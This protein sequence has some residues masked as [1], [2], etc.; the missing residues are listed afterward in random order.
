MKLSTRLPLIVL[1]IS[2][3]IFAINAFSLRQQLSQ[4]QHDS[5]ELLANTLIQSMVEAVTHDVILGDQEKLSYLLQRTQDYQNSPIEYLYVTGMNGQIFAHSFNRGIPVFLYDNLDSHRHVNSD[6]R[7]LKLV[8][9]YK[10]DGKGLVYEYEQSL[11][12]GLAARI[13]IG[14]NQS[15]IEAK[16]VTASRDLLLI[17]AFLSL[18]CTLI[19]WLV[20]NGV[21]R[22]FKELTALLDGYQHGGA[23]DFEK[24][25]HADPEV[26]LL[27]ETLE[28]VFDSRDQAAEEIRARERDLSVTLNSIG[29]AVIAT[30]E[31]G[32]VTR[33][34][35][36]AEQL[37][38]WTLDEA[39]GQKI[40]NVF[41]IIDETT[42]LTIA[43][44]IEKVL[45][46]GQ[47]VYLSNHTTLTSKDGTQYQ[48]ADSAAPIRNGDN[49]ILGMVLVFNDISKEYLLRE[50]LKASL[51]RFQLYWEESPVGIIDW[52]TNF[53]FIDLNPAAEKIFGFTA[54]ELK[55]TFGLDSIL[56]TYTTEEVEQVWSTLMTGAMVRRSQNTNRMKDGTTVFCDWYNTPLVN[57]KGVVIGVT[58]LVLDVSEQ[59]RLERQEQDS[60]KQLE[61]L[62]N[63]M[64][65][66]V[67]TMLPDG[68]ITFTNEPALA[69]LGIDKVD[70]LGEI[71]SS[72]PWISESEQQIVKDECQRVAK[73]ETISR[74]MEISLA[75]GGIWVDYSLHP[76]Y[77]SQGKITLLVVEGR[78]ARKRK[79]A[80]EQVVRSQKM[81]ALSQIVGGIAHDYNNMLGVIIGYTD[82]LKN[83][84]TGIEG[85]EKFLDR[86]IHAADRGK[87]LTRKML[88]FSRPESGQ[89]E[90]CDIN[91]TLISF[92]DILAKSLTSVVQLDYDLSDESWNVW[93]DLGEL[94]D[95]VLNIAINAKY[96][97]PEGGHLTV[98]TENIHLDDKGAGF[99]NLAPNDY[100]KLS[101]RDTGTGIDEA[102]RKKMFE[103]FFSTKGD[104]GSGLGL[105]QVFGFIQRCGGSVNV[106]SQLGLGTQIN[107]Y[108]PR[109]KSV[110]V[111]KE[112]KQVVEMTNQYKGDGVILVVDDEPA[113]RELAREILLTAGYRII[114]ANDG[115][116]ALDKL[117]HNKVDLV[118]SDVIMPNMDGYQLADKVMVEYPAIKIQLT[119]GFSG[120]RHIGYDSAELKIKI[121]NK[122]YDNNELLKRVYTL[123]NDS[124]SK[125]K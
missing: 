34:N 84:Y 39:R 32:N 22:P 10:I 73:G 87:K 51:E 33:M 27:T 58:S 48:I 6:A 104:V 82:L 29:D 123:L 105:S 88:S 38:G 30:D 80:E 9:K 103:P 37:T 113:L 106:Y 41:S 92:E 44:P 12:A 54:E 61:Q 98:C 16:V 122:P 40:N 110:V 70:V 102:T 77:D 31:K 72:S 64:L 89:A 111:N 125:Q 35:P 76:V 21:T 96:A 26:R 75:S 101:I 63:G 23:V 121:L 69:I 65:T 107:L 114:T 116:E 20:T 18:L 60:K 68:T 52:N 50:Q 79:L 86:I 91:K 115:I 49:E 53:E 13:H 24:I 45:A 120:G 118:L 2:I 36:I 108:F 67:A 43:S 4:Q 17:A 57:E 97:M 3:V 46:T 119:S 112:D 74:E 94:E 11:I 85:A 7:L 19:A 42:G 100:V 59:L 62:M 56:G 14:L 99:L 95:A 83:K 93:L 81:E 5:Q 55:G 1:T 90:P 8:T 25:S 78:D 117:A 124:K 15:K 47:I 71:F 66:M 109:Y 28:D